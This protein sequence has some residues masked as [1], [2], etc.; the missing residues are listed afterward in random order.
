[1][2]RHKKHTSTSAFLRTPDKCNS[3]KV[4]CCRLLLQNLQNNTKEEIR[5]SLIVTF[6]YS[7]VRMH[8]MILQIRTSID[9]TTQSLFCEDLIVVLS[10]QSERA[11]EVRSWCLHCQVQHLNSTFRR[12]STNRPTHIRQTACHTSKRM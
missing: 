9:T 1:M 11:F 4:A 5:T 2:S 7:F 3:F 8:I 6:I 10:H 12:Y